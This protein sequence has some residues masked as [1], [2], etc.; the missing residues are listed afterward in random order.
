MLKPLRA[1]ALL[2]ALSLACS[3]IASADIMVDLGGSLQGAQVKIPKDF[4]ETALGI[5]AFTRLHFT[6]TW[7][8]DIAYAAHG[9]TDAK[10]IAIGEGQNQLACAELREEFGEGV[11]DECITGEFKGQE[12][13][14][15]VTYE[16]PF[17]SVL[18]MYA[19]AGVSVWDAT[20]TTTVRVP[21]GRL[22]V[23]KEDDGADPYGQLGF[24]VR[25]TE[26][27]HWRIQASMVSWDNIDLVPYEL[28]VFYRF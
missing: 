24:S 2:V 15:G 8:M 25:A 9:E 18:T 10:F 28:G 6:P 4:D 16:Y 27:L 17:N 3:G 21:G 22:S 26:H 14:L 5:N 12:L 1:P 19:G 7:A 11:A 23:K 13:R 20:R